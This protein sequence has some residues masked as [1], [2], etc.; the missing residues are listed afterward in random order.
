MTE[1][2]SESTI[3]REGFS[4]VEVLVALV[5]LSIGVL[6]V[7]GMATSSVTLVRNGFNLTNSTLAAQQVLDNYMITP[8][9][10]IPTGTRADT[11][12]LGGQVYTVASTVTDVS[13]QL[14]YADADILYQIVVYA[15]G[16]ANQNY[17]ER[18]EAFIYNGDDGP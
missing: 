9:D 7:T 8:F 12:T 16:G 18:F 11:I 15:G 5:V 10:S 2:R 4:L 13:A 17:A 1:K 6:A 3:I 14:A